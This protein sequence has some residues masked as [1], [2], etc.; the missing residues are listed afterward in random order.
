MGKEKKRKVNP[1]QGFQIFLS[2]LGEKFRGLLDPRVVRA[3]SLS[4]LFLT[5]GIIFLIVFTTLSQRKQEENKLR[6]ESNYERNQKM[7]LG[8][9]TVD[10][11]ILPEDFPGPLREI[12]L[13]REPKKIW[14]DEE[15]SEYWI[16]LD[17]IVLDDFSEANRELIRN[18]LDTVP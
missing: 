11:L 12:Y 17:D 15:V 10:D 13:F 5:A 6:A 1:I 4:A 16:D 14:T 9:P 7:L 2:N 8:G 3:I 18:K